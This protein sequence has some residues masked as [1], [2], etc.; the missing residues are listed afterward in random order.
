MK[1]DLEI[2]IPAALDV[3]KSQK[4]KSMLQWLS[5]KLHARAGAGLCRSRMIM[6][7]RCISAQTMQQAQKAD[8]NK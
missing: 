7:L 1:I 2:I 5:F 6:G 3:V 4:Y 8:F